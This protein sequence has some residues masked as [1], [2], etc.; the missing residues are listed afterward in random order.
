MAVSYIAT[1]LQLATLTD[2][3]RENANRTAFSL[4]LW[5]N[6]VQC[7]TVATDLRHEARRMEAQKYGARDARDRA[8]SRRAQQRLDALRE[9]RQDRRLLPMPGGARRDRD[10]QRAAHR[11][12]R[13]LM[14]GTRRL[15]LYY[16]VPTAELGPCSLV[17]ARPLLQPGPGMHACRKYRP[18][19]RDGM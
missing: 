4:L 14:T 6:I 7:S 10:G 9:L 3:E 18:V 13:C 2:R 1:I 12:T 17:P 8:P 5:V 19:R 16:Y 15:L 11:H